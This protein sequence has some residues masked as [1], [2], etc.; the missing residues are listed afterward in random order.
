MNY[1]KEKQR[2]NK[3]IRTKSGITL[4]ALVITVIVLLILAGVSIAMLTG[5]NGILNQAK[6]A[7]QLTEIASE[8]EYIRL[9]ITEEALTKEKIGEELKEVKF[10]TVEDTKSIIDSETGTT[11]ANG[12]YYL[13]PE[14]VNDY[15]LKNSYIIDY[16]TGEFVKYNEEKH[17]IVTNELLCIKEGLV[18][19]ADPKNITNS[20][21]WGD[22]ILHNFIE[23]EENSGWTE[24]SLMFDGI[25]DGIEVKDNSDY[26]K[27]ITL[28]IYFKLK[29][30]GTSD[31]AQILMMK[32]TTAS[33]GFFFYLNYSNSEKSML[34]ID[35][36]GSGIGVKDEEGNWIM[37]N[38]FFTNVIVQENVPTYITYTYNPDKESKNG[39][40]YVNGIKTETTNLG[41]IENLVNTPENT[42]IQ[43]GSDVYE[44][45]K[46]DGDTLNRKYP[47]YGEIYA[48]RVYN[49]PLTESEVKYNYE[50]TVN[51]SK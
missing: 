24:N 25:D 15:N 19:S 20:N 45:Y 5:E 30:K 51:N 39:I 33:N 14:D 50:M 44:T 3:C 42:P 16:E 11:Y 17:R 6:K 9:I 12:W 7:K 41:I 21:S 29:G 37:N 32:R 40:L 47:F 36:G 31:I 1:S 43:I 48:S 49:R 8:E 22:A 23:G 34:T 27:G 10:N 13:K 35:M 38:R 26:S 28:E 46:P 2:K 4:I 18:Y